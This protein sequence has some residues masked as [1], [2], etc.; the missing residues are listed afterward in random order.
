MVP[1]TITNDEVTDVFVQAALATVATMSRAED[2]A[3]HFAVMEFEAWLLA[4]EHLLCRAFPTLAPEMVEQE[5]GCR[6]SDIDPQRCFYRPSA[7][8]D[9]I[10]RRIG[11][12]HDKSRHEL[13]R[14]CACL[15][16][17]DISKAT[18]H[19][20]CRNLRIF[21]EAVRRCLE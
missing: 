12:E 15:T 13:E 8:L 17:D 2:I 21:Y 7:E 11:S 20:R 9:R 4:M 16:P 6:L 5:L 18:E 19:G 14:I 1:G 10:L 3:M